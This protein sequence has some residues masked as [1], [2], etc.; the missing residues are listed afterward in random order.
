MYIVGN[1]WALSTIATVGGA[2]APGDCKCRPLHVVQLPCSIMRLHPV[3][4]GDSAGT[5]KCVAAL[6]GLDP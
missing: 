3:F 6:L 4:R 5:A 2:A 1:Y